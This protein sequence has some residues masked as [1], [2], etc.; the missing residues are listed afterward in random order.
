MNDDTALSA[1]AEAMN[2]IN[3]VWLHGDIAD[4]EALMH[5]D[6]VML[7]PGFTGAVR[8]RD[9][10]IAGFHDFRNSAAI[11]DFREDDRQI[12]VAGNAAV[13]SYRYEISGCS[14]AKRCVDSRLAHHAGRGRKTR[15]GVT[16][17]EPSTCYPAS[18]GV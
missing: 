9:E 16:N 7:L 3:Q 10:L 6:F 15:L 4:L 12:D 8:G 2:R 14:K 5:P 13:V 11:Q 17:T 1:A 18:P